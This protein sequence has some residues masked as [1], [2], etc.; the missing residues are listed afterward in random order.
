MGR[1][2]QGPVVYGLGDGL[3]RECITAKAPNLVRG[4]AGRAVRAWRAV[5][6]TLLEEGALGYQQPGDHGDVPRARRDVPP[7]V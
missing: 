7:M 1:R 2:H 6:K 4:E 3:N 5:A